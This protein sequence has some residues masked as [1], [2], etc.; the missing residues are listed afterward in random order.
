MKSLFGKVKS[1]PPPSETILKLRKTLEQ[2]EKRE[3][4]LELKVKAELETAKKNASINRRA[5][6]MALKKK[7]IYEQQIEKM[8]NVRV[9][10]EAQIIAIES[11][12][13]NLVI[14]NS[15][16]EGSLALKQI[17]ERM[18]IEKVEDTMDNIQEQITLANDIVEAISTPLMNDLDE[19]DL[20]AEL[21]SLKTKVSES[22]TKLL[23]TPA[24]SSSQT[25]TDVEKL[26]KEEA[27]A[28]LWSGLEMEMGL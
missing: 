25:A 8:V 21:E 24:A 15:M 10:L 11:A 22:E 20:N 1:A 5:A 26:E 27:E 14:V 9:T 18:T 4:Y 13:T 16:V 2:L 28:K 23:K 12:S 19:E 3:D 17:N 7:R 6:L